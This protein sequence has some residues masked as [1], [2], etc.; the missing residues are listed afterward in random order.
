M[1]K[2]SGFTLIELM[3]VVA[4]IAILA[5]IALPAYN[6]YTAKAKYSEAITA[7]AGVKDM[8]EMCYSD[9][10]TVTGC[11][12]EKSG[13]G[14]NIKKDTDY[15]RGI[16]NSVGVTDG[17]ITV[18]STNGTGA[19]ATATYKLTPTVVAGVGLKWAIACSNDDLCDDK[20]G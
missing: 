2:Q 12:N 17:V 1:K 9:L 7:G 11:T 18:N 6:G 4:I 5:A 15:A 19:I 16:V 20:A 3:I 13:S 10:N 14:W 8:V